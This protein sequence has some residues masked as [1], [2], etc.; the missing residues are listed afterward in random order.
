MQNLEQTGP[1]NRVLTDAELDEINGGSIM[2]T[3][4]RFVREAFG[5]HGD[6]RRPTS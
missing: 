1:E 2:G 6:Q 3:L 5:G 4:V